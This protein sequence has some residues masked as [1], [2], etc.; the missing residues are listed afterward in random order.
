MAVNLTDYARADP[1]GVRAD[2][3]LVAEVIGGKTI[4]TTLRS[5]PPLTL[6]ATPEGVYIVGTLAGP[7]GGDE[8]T[9]NVTA[10]P[11][12]FLEIR[13][14]AA[15]VVLPGPGGSPS[16]T[17]FAFD[18]GAGAT[19]D[20][21]PEPLVLA[22]AS[23]HR[24]RTLISASEGAAVIWRD[25]VVLGRH[26]EESGSLLQRLRVEV[27]ARPVLCTEVGLGPLWAGW[28]GPCGVGPARCV[29]SLLVLG[30]DSSRLRSVVGAIGSQTDLRAAV[31]DLDGGGVL[32]S[33]LSENPRA[34]RSFLDDL[35]TGL[36]TPP[37]A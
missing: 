25:E 13:S 24:G 5:A 3:T 29:G 4:Y 15:S 33:V 20:W 6:R 7:L 32:V 17:S 23:N 16:S 31:F 19:L 18:V 37:R 28:D 10:A 34:A 27:D 8:L 36:R 9:L 22:R 14:S 12:A 30:R 1:A 26:G 11:E 21:Q 2:A 35:A